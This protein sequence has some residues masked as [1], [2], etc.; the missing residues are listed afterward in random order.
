MRLKRIRA[1]QQVEQP[2]SKEAGNEAATPPKTKRR[3][4]DRRCAVSGAPAS[5]REMT[6]PGGPRFGIHE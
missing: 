3:D 4:D 5:V 1:K 2:K 6:A